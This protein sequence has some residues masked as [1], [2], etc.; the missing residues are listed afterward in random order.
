L[1]IHLHDF[2][3]VEIWFGLTLRTHSGL[4]CGSIGCSW[5]LPFTRFLSH[6]R[7]QKA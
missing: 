7:G 5:S 3:L 6:T 1:N 2:P 4:G